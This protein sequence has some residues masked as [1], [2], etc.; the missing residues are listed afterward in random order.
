MGFFLKKT[1]NQVLRESVSRKLRRLKWLKFAVHKKKEVQDHSFFLY[2]QVESVS[3]I[4]LKAS[5]VFS[6]HT[7]M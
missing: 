6:M 5:M 4:P 2:V 1:L 3:H 7:C